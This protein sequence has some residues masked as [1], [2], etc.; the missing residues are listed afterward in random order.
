MGAGKR[1]W[2]GQGDVAGGAVR[3][4]WELELRFFVA[5]TSAKA[6]NSVQALTEGIRSPETMHRPKLRLV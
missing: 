5:I 2:A 6:E 4:L 1:S 3:C